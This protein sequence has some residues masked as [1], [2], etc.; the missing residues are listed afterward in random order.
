MHEIVCYVFLP[1]VILILI[2][3]APVSV[4]AVNSIP[5]NVS[6]QNQVMDLQVFLVEHVMSCGQNRQL[7]L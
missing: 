1:G 7:C 6:Q 2:P 5:C 3:A 4:D